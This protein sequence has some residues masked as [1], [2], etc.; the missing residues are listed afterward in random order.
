VNFAKRM[1]I[2]KNPL[3]LARLK[4]DISQRELAKIT[5]ISRKGLYFIEH[6]ITKS[7]RIDTLFELAKVLDTDAVVLQEDIKKWIKQD[8]EK[9]EEE[10]GS[11]EGS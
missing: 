11:N 1:W 6:G 7:P 4:K 9:E 3:R 5:S 2:E 8:P 10:D